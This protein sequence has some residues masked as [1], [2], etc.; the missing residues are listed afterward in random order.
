MV[1]LFIS[2]GFIVFDIITGF[3]KAFYHKDIDS[4]LL[5][6][7]LFHKLSEVLALVGSFLLGYVA[8][9]I[10]LGFE[11][12]LLNVVSIYICTMELISIIENLCE[13]NPQMFSLFSPYLKKLKPKEGEKVDDW[14]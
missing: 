14:D 1:Q 10:E 3:V 12:P 4:T 5:R 7:G 13:V 9:Y 11:L 6:K 8:E 2:C